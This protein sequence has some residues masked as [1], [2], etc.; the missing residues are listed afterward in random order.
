MIRGVLFDLMGTLL[1]EDTLSPGDPFGNF[2]RVLCEA[3]LTMDRDEL[4]AALGRTPPAAVPPPATPFVDRLLRICAVGGLHLS[5]AEAGALAEAI[6]YGSNRVLMADPE[7]AGAMQA[8]R[9]YGSVGLVTNYDHPPNIHYLLQRER[10]QT[11]FDVV[12]ISG[13]IG[14][15]KPDPAI[16]FNALDAL[17]LS[18]GDA[19]YVGD[20]QIDIEAAHAAGMPCILIERPGGPSD[21]LREKLSPET[22]VAQAEITIASL[23]D[24]SRAVAQLQSI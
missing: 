12:T 4:L 14:I 1:I 9:H 19:V 5:L 13:E 2:H 23:A 18:A 16:L 7:A 17:G 21:P 10:W 11:C 20:S 15:W 6:C 24:L 8:M 3:G 22:T